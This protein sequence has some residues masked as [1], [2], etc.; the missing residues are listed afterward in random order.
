MDADLHIIPV[1]N[2]IDLP[3]AQPEKYA[4]ELAGLIGCDPSDVLRVSGKT[5]VGVR[6]AA[7]P[8]RPD[9]SPRPSATP[10][11]PPAR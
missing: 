2:K 6:G 1:L 3:A 11:R 8:R 5:G 10:T 7:R 4:E 9:A